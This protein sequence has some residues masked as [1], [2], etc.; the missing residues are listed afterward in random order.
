MAKRAWILV[1]SLLTLIFIYHLKNKKMNFSNKKIGIALAIH[2]SPYEYDPADIVVTADYEIVHNL[3]GRL[4]KLNNDQKIEGMLAAKIEV[5]DE[6]IRFFLKKV[7]TKNGFVLDPEDVKASFDRLLKLNKNTHFKLTNI[8]SSSDPISVDPESKSV[9]FKLKN[10]KLSGDFLNIL[11]TAD[12]S[13]IPKKCIDDKTLKIVNLEDTF[14]LYRLE[15]PVPKN[16]DFRFRLLANK[17]HPDFHPQNPEILEFYS[18]TGTN[19]AIELFK[20]KKVD[21]IPMTGR[22]DKLLLAE[23]IN[24]NSDQV[25][26]SKTLPFQLVR[27][28]F[29]K[30][31]IKELAPSR[32]VAIAEKFRKHYAYRYQ[33]YKDV[34]MTEQLIPRGGL[35][36]LRTT[37]LLQLKE[38]DSE[39]LKNQPPETGKE[40]LIASTEVFAPEVDLIKKNHLPDLKIKKVNRPPILPS[41]QGLSV[42]DPHLFIS[43]IDTAFNEDITLI[44]YAFTTQ[45]FYLPD[46][47]EQEKWIN[48]FMLEGSLGREKMIHDIHLKT[49]ESKTIFPILAMPYY[50]VVRKPLIPDFPTTF[51]GAGAEHI[52]FPG[53]F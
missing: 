25:N 44:G 5:K 42:D 39:I 18:A 31:G 2:R 21:W 30:R 14:G 20:S 19:T 47:K 50:S 27:I 3:H 23:F 16:A 45:F 48:Q 37:E 24:E 35:G 8:L 11:A 43:N 32:R 34:S 46:V 53:V 12:F 29:T 41:E 17:D 33:K 52:L 10:K 9:V 51:P 28:Q 15:Q 7:K 40:V 26:Y 49:I 1:I 36:E 22:V 13:I 38:K 4:V 6:N